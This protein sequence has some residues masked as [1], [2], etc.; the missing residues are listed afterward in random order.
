MIALKKVSFSYTHKRFAPVCVFE[1]VDA[2]FEKGKLYVLY[3]PSGAGKSTLLSLLGGLSFPQ[4]GEIWID[5]VSLTKG[6]GEDCRRNKV[7]Y[8]FQDYSL[9]PYMNAVE[10]VEMAI[11][12]NKMSGKEKKG[13]ASQHLQELG[14]Q[15]EEM[16]RSIRHLSGGQQQ[17]IGIARALATGADYLLADEPT[18]NL[19]AENADI[20]TG[21]FKKLA[22]EKNKCVI[23]ASHSRE[24]RAQADV[25]LYVGDHTLTLE[26]EGQ[27][28]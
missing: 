10:N 7:S 19:D 9:F 15:E 22:H 23:V 25:V 3:G 20:V 4:S 21:I 27:I 17:R 13:L 14:I 5:D 24:L 12:N 11:W 16:R 2:V 1:N 26:K 8:I 28:Q 6:N 18:G